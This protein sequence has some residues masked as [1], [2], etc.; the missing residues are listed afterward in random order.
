M[1]AVILMD[2]RTGDRKALFDIGITGPLAGLIPTLV[3]CIVGLQHSKLG[4]PDPQGGFGEPLVFQ[5][6]SYLR[7]G[8]RLEGMDVVI[9]PMAMAGWV[10]LFIT[11]LNLLP[12]GQLDGGHILYGLLRWRARPVAT[13]LL[14]AAIGAVIYFQMVGWF[15]MIFLLLLMGP[16][17][18]PTTDDTVPLGPWRMILGWLTLAFLP[19][20]FTPNPFPE[21]RPLPLRHEP[22]GEWDLVWQGRAAALGTF[23]WPCGGATCQRQMV[24]CNPLEDWG[25]GLGGIGQ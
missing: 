8:P 23:A 13:T 14:I 20:G 18:P 16:A 4:F 11:A 2:P 15:L 25:L 10:G 22:A 3:F 1:G 21:P 6:L 9:G 24:A 17:H 5:F 12:I 19:F 7:F